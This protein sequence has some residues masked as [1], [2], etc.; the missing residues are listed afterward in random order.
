MPQ[1]YADADRPT[2]WIRRL[3]V[4]AILMVIALAVLFYWNQQ[5][6]ASLEHQRAVDNRI[7][8]VMAVA[9]AETTTQL[10]LLD[11]NWREVPE[12]ARALTL[13]EGRRLDDKTSIQRLRGVMQRWDKLMQGAMKR[14]AATVMSSYADLFALRTEVQRIEPLSRCLTEVRI[15]I[16][17]GITAV[18]PLFSEYNQNGD[19]VPRDAMIATPRLLDQADKM[20]AGCEERAK[21]MHYPTVTAAMTL[22]EQSAT[23]KELVEFQRLNAEWQ[24]IFA[25]SSNREPGDLHS[26]LQELAELRSLVEARKPGGC[27]SEVRIRML[28]GIDSHIQSFDQLLLHNPDKAR[29]FSEEGTELQT[30][31]TRNLMDCR[32][33]V[34]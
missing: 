33:E 23:Q 18:I 29:K 30:Q 34:H 24:G 10:R 19:T 8:Q 4:L 28:R 12:A 26:P 2:R 5:V 14:P 6:R 9:E 22:D 11:N 32:N 13:R 17:E 7:R 1:H 15:H 20:I 27:L 31:A 25:R 16:S 21:A 3:T